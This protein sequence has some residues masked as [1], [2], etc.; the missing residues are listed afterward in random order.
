MEKNRPKK[1]FAAKPLADLLKCALDPLLARRGFSQSGLILY[2]DEIAGQRLAEH[3]QPV[4]LAWPTR[5]SK[6][7]KALA[8]LFLRVEPGFGL[9]FQHLRPVIIDRINAHLGWRCV[10]KVT[11]KQEPLERSE[12][13]RPVRTST[14]PQALLHASKYVTAI[15]DEAL[16]TALTRLGA[17]VMTAGNKN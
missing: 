8:T 17:R 4:K 7:E 1:F 13:R 12:S 9:E 3:S 15:E 6:D 16:R 2:W 14:G 11:L 5:G 10:G